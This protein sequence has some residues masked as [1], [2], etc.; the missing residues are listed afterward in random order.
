MSGSAVTTY[1]EPAVG[2]VPQNFDEAA[3]M[4]KA[5]STM[6]GLPDWLHDS[7]GDCLLIVEQS[8]RWK[9]S[10]FA[11]AQCTSMIHG[12]L[13]FEG[14]LVAAAVETSGML[15]S[16]FT[17]RHGG[18]GDDRQVTVSAMLRGEAQ[19]R[20]LTVVL[21]DVRTL[22]KSGKVNRQWTGG[23][24]DQQL[25]YAAVRAWARRYTPAVMLGV[26]SGEEFDAPQAPGQPFVGTT[27]EAETIVESPARPVESPP[28]SPA[29]ASA[30][31]RE[32][33]NTEVPLHEPPAAD[34]PAPPAR[35]PRM[36]AWVDSVVSR[37]EAA[38]GPQALFALIDEVRSDRDTLR[39]QAPELEARIDQAVRAA[40]ARLQPKPE[41][42]PA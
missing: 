36:V 5:M 25:G 16:H 23:Q 9:M 4:A 29:P 18:A 8:M 34:D 22:D 19:P 31:L 7:P 11:V 13:M 41:D 1:R 33:M 37:I 32:A 27:L 12:K 30:D 15:A 24:V 38:I 20:E 3:R 26:Y 14:K 40:N 6:K 2:L 17:Y 28:R 42:K 39:Q 35:D 21:R 10:P